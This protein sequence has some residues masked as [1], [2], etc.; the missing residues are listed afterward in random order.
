[1]HVVAAWANSQRRQTMQRAYPNYYSGLTINDSKSVSVC[2]CVYV[3]ACV[4]VVC[5]CVFVCVCVCVCTSP[6]WTGSSTG[7]R[8]LGEAGRWKSETGG[9]RSAR[10][11]LTWWGL[12]L[13]LLVPSLDV[14]TQWYSWGIAYRAPAFRVGIHC[15]KY[16]LILK[17]QCTSHPPLL[18]SV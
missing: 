4:C 1:M 14:L 9:K 12:V 2:I 6:Q 15:N 18:S 10:P 7:S 8:S 5:V 16:N 11:S 17:S 3:C 13:K